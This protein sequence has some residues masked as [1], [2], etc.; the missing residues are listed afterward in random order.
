MSGE[1]PVPNQSCENNWRRDAKQQHGPKPNRVKDQERT[2]ARIYRSLRVALEIRLRL[3]RSWFLRQR[4]EPKLLKVLLFVDSSSPY[5][6]PHRQ[7]G[8]APRQPHLR[9]RIRMARHSSL[10][11]Q[12]LLRGS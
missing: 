7:T 1:A 10:K 6:G 3:T 9:S 11:K 12:K 8:P 2:S 4:R 5:D